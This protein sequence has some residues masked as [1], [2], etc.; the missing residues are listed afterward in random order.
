M[1]NIGSVL[2]DEIIRLCRRELRKQLRTLQK[3]TATYRHDIAALKRQQA[4]QDRITKGLVKHLEKTVAAPTAAASEASL[5][6]R[7]DGFRS[8]R[9]KLGISAE[10]MAKLLGVSAQSVYAWEQKRSAPRRAQLPMIAAVRSMGKREVMA[11]LAARQETSK[12]RPTATRH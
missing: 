4:D 7:A 1:A 10:Q 6:F 12:K 8:L 11:K 2:R 9:K 5:R 3:A